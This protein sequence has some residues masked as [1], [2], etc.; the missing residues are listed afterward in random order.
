MESP[1]KIIENREK[2]PKPDLV[3]D[4]IRHGKT[5]Y[6]EAL[7][8]KIGDIGQN[9]DTFKQM[10]RVADTVEG[11][12]EQLEG[13]ITAE[14]EVELR[15]AAKKLAGMID[16]QN[17][18]VAIV[19]GTRTRHTQSASIIE[20]EL[21]NQGID[22]VKTKEH[23]DLVDVKGGGWY[24]FVD[25]I[26]KHQGKSD[27]DL[28]QFWWEMYQN[29]NTREDMSAKGYEH[30]GDIA[31]RTEKIAEL[32]RRFVRRYNL[33]KTLRV[34]SVASD[35]NI[36]QIQQKG[37]PL[38]NRDQIWVKNADVVE[39]KIWNDKN[40]ALLKEEIVRPFGQST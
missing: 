38:E 3:I 24:T 29:E 8:K 17:E 1:E 23:E 11:E 2:A 36:E 21:R 14:G 25:Y 15:E 22:V 31:T 19:T 4:F 27:A 30:L 34:I 12:Q 33:G 7:K 26:L 16:L 20:D 18:I 35:I 32:L 10:P 5:V 13:V 37:I 9:P 28:E 39:I 40:G 6:G